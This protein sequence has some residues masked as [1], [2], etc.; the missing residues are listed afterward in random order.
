MLCN[1]HHY[2][3]WLVGT[4]QI[5]LKFL[6]E[7]YFCLRGYFVKGVTFK[8]NVDTSLLDFFSKT[9]NLRGYLFTQ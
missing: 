1:Q 2:I 7:K 9:V 5:K 4:N 8:K 6:L 3:L